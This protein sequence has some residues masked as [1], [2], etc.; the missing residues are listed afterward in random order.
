LRSIRAI[1]VV[2]VLFG[3]IAAGAE[4]QQPISGPLAAQAGRGAQAY[5]QSCAPCHQPN[6]QGMGVAAAL[7]GPNFQTNWASRTAAEL[8]DRIRLTMPPGNP[9]GIPVETKTDILTHI[10]NVNGLLSGS[11]MLTAGAPLAAIPL[12]PPTAPPARQD[13]LHP[14]GES[15][16]SPFVLPVR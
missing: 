13:V 1:T 3:T 11:A 10:L 7:A 4:A 5:A 12:A 16:L 15:S 6:L 8:Y 9:S 14:A 2:G